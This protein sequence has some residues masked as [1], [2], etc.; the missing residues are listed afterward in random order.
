MASEGYTLQSL[1]YNIFIRSDK[2]VFFSMDHIYV[3]HHSLKKVGERTFKIFALCPSWPLAQLVELRAV[4][5][6]ITHSWEVGPTLRALKISK[7]LD[8]Q[9]FSDKDYKPEVPSHNPCSLT[10][11]D[12]KE[13]THFSQRVGHGVP[14]VVVWSFQHVVGL[15]GLAWRASVWMRLRPHV[16]GDFCIRKFFYADTKISASTR[17]VYESYTTLHTYPIRIRTSQRISQQSSR[18]KSLVLILWRQ[19]I[20]TYTDTCVHTYP[21]TQHIQK[22]TDMETGRFAYRPIR[23]HWSRFPYTSKGDSPTQVNASFANFLI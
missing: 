9:V 16:S 7:W 22:Y 2:S 19:R 23:L 11:W 3:L 10:L 6:E 15:A 4:T 5:R 1:T 8:F 18:G 21:D 17:S 12:V 14:G 20:Q 13:P